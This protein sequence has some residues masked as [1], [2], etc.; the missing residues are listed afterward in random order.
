[1]ESAK[2]RL[3]TPEDKPPDSSRDTQ[4]GDGRR[5]LTNASTN[6]MSPLF[7]F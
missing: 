6:N 5:D 7:G 4:E 1:M 3:P 2:S